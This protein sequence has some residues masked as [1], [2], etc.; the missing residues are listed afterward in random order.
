VSD[1]TTTPNLGLFKPN[2]ALDVG[3]WGNHLNANA[4]VLDAVLGAAGASGI[5]ALAVMARN[6]AI[7]RTNNPRVNP[8][9]TT[10][11]TVTQSGTP[12]AALTR[13][14]NWNDSTASVYNF[15]GGKPTA[16]IATFCAFNSVTLN[17]GPSAFVWRVECA[18]DAIK[19]Q[20][21]VFNYGGTH[22]RFLVNDQYVAATQTTVTNTATSYITLDFT[23]A[24]GRAVRKIALEGENA[25]VFQAFSVLPTES[26]TKPGGPVSRMFVVSD[27]FGCAGGATERF[28]G[29]PQVLGDLL[30]IRDVW[31]GGVSG[32]GY[33][34]QGAGQATFRQ[35][36]S[37]M[38]QAAPDIVLSVGGHNDAGPSLLRDEITAYLSAIRAQS[39]L[40]N[41][42]I[43]IGGVNGANQATAT[44][45]PL[46]NA[47]AAAI[48]AFA[49][50]LVY[51]VPEIT[52]SAGPYFTGTGS[53][54]GA[55][56]TGNCDVYISADAVHPNDAGHAYLAGRL[57]DDITRLLKA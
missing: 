4:D 13:T 17:G 40:R 5:S 34:N 1:Y 15:Y 54:A 43:I 28:K 38:T 47:M 39:T 41:V 33:L 35:R 32:T 23:A 29:F 11:P 24:G 31:N 42:P 18:V 14:V 10:P 50:P 49:D 30:G 55:T 6:A 44:T 27:S 25:L 12:D 51:F 56:G 46:E 53:T 19:V 22:C 9:M 20:F 16:D 3:Q 21:T 8:V 48:T 37:D 45:I 57:A 52:G 2:Y 36:L 26:L 7:A